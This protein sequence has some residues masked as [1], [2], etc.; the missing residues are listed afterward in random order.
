MKRRAYS[1]GLP[2]EQ[3]ERARALRVLGPDEAGVQKSITSYLDARNV[4]YAVTNARTVETDE[5]KRQLVKPAGWPDITA[6]LPITGRLWAIEVKTEKG[7]LREAQ[8]DMLALIEASGGLRTVARDCLII[9]QILNDHL[10]QYETP[11]L[12]SYFG[13]IELLKRL[14]REHHAARK[15]KAEASKLRRRINQR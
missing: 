8:E 6:I 4:V 3:G 9:R 15:A 14:Y 1:G 5:G 2:F 13:T 12:L 7:K 10:A 11:A